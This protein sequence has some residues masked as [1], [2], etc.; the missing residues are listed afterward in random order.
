ML[1]IIQHFGKYCGCH[2]QGEDGNLMMATAIFAETF[3]NFQHSMRL[4]PESRSCTSKS[5]RENLRSRMSI[6]CSDRA[7]THTA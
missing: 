7:I 3:D 4:I 6:I 2:L 5:S 1:K